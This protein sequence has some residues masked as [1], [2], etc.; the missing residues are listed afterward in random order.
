M[1][2]EQLSKIIK[3]NLEFPEIKNLGQRGVADK[4]EDACNEIITKHFQ[5]VRPAKSN[6]SI[7]DINVG[8]VY[9]DHKSSDAS[10]DF[11]MPNMISISRLMKLDRDLVYNFIVYDS[12]KQKIL[13]T[14]ALGVYELNWDHLTIQNL[15]K[16]QL[17]IINMVEFLKSPKSN[18]SKGEWIVE[19]KTRAIK[20][21]KKVQQDA[22][23]RQSEWEDW[24]I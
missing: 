22:K 21:Y 9:V 5:E 4:I 15:G 19:L 2:T 23:K 10:R 24:V 11:K 8:N 13:N 1:F 7:E 18:L 20:F 3:E 12:K 6:R 17:Q 16:G 14:F